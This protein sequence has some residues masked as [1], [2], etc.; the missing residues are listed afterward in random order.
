MSLRVVSD[1]SDPL[2]VDELQKRGNRLLVDARNSAL[3]ALRASLRL[4]LIYEPRSYSP[5]HVQQMRAQADA[6]VA[7]WQEVAGMLAEL[8]RE[9]DKANNAARVGKP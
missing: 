5:R 6:A 8:T 7:A 2:S 9:F 4:E 1:E 3:R